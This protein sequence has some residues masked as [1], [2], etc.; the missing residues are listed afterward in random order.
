METQ[1]GGEIEAPNFGVGGYGLDQ[2]Y[3][4][5]GRNAARYHPDV[6]LVGLTVFAIERTTNLYRPFYSHGNRIA[7]VKP[8][9]VCAGDSLRAVIGAVPD[10]VLFA[11]GLAGFAQGP[12]R[13]YE[14]YYD[15]T[16]YESS[17]IDHSRLAW[18]VRSRLAWHERG[19]R[20]RVERILGAESEETAISRL[21]LRRMKAETEAMGAQFATVILPST[22][23]LHLLRD[24]HKDPWAAFRSSLEQAGI[25]VW[26]ILP[27][28]VNEGACAPCFLSDG[29]LTPEANA[30]VAAKVVEH[31][32]S[33]ARRSGA[34]QAL[35][36][37]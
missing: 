11:R 24:E 21:I 27:A 37:H 30:L 12:L 10:P 7:L 2:A 34:S 15:P 31:L 26:D 18:F 22:R 28:L 1:T 3:L 23:T 25:E 5:F 19:D 36:T 29:H 9:F 13:S 20:F 4:C 32:K 17:W 33:A 35:S 6:V 16:I 14:G 8:R